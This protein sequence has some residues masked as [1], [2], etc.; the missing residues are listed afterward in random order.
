L[1]VPG[2]QQVLLKVR[3]A[4][5]N[6]T[7]FRQ[8]GA[9]FLAASRKITAGTQIG[10]ALPSAAGSVSAGSLTGVAESLLGPSN[11]AF[12]IFEQGDFAVF[13]SALRRNSVLR[14]LAEPNLVALNGHAATFLAGG[15]F[16]V[17]VPQG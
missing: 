3:V 16:P 8:I 10:G 1:R 4:E 7:A 9:D 12:A 15:E 11:T 5:L 6:R 14:V 13:L 17:P 2:S